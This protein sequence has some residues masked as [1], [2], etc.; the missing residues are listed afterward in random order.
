MIM[1][2]F[3]SLLREECTN[4]PEEEETCKE[5][6]I[7]RCVDNFVKKCIDIPLQIT[8]ESASE[9]EATECATKVKEECVPEESQECSVV[10]KTDCITV[11]RRECSTVEKESSK[12]E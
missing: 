2:F 10:P 12:L 11:T 9:V 3:N 4:V 1:D 7:T 6:T 8:K 5:V